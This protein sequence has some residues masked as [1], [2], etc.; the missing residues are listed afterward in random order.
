MHAASNL[1]AS[2]GYSSRRNV[3]V[4]P[5]ETRTVGFR[6]ADWPEFY[7][8]QQAIKL[9]GSPFSKV[10]KYW[11]SE[12]R[13]QRRGRRNQGKV[14]LSHA[15][16][17]RL[18][19]KHFPAYST[20]APL[21]CPSLGKCPI[22]LNI[23]LH[24]CIQTQTQI[25]LP[26]RSRRGQ[27]PTLAPISSTNT[28]ALLHSHQQSTKSHRHHSHSKYI[29]FHLACQ[30]L[31][32]SIPIQNHPSAAATCAGLEDQSRQPERHDLSIAKP[33]VPF[34]QPQRLLQGF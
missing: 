7:Q 3:D 32:C 29:P 8:A 34:R 33:Q 20:N 12:S 9:C 30:L 23:L 2:R 25:L 10:K 11:F 13:I 5:G 27:A 14:R 17:G 19:I 21:P 22:P 28:L 31:Y 4:R 6:I 26:P 16:I 18:N 15:N 1:C 24:G